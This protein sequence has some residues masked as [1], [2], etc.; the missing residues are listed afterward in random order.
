MAAAA[1]PGKTP[2][3]MSTRASGHSARATMPSSTLVTP[4]HLCPCAND[5]GSAESERVAVGVGLDDGEQLGVRS[6]EASEKAKVF[7][8]SAG[9]N[10][11]PAGARW[12]GGRQRTVYGKGWTVDA[13]CRL[14]PEHWLCICR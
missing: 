1:W 6:G 5:R 8:E 12:H 3:M 7:L 10:L 2:P 11:N 9:A 14:P 13:E 4:S